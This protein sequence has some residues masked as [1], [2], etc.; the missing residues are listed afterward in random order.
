MAFPNITEFK[1]KLLDGGARP[2]LFQMELTFP[3]GV[4]LGP[5]LGSPNFPFACTISE[6]PGISFNPIT[7]KYAGR[8]VKYAGSRI[9]RNLT[10]TVLNDNGFRIRKA[11]EN[12]MDLIQSAESN[13]SALTS[14]L[15]HGATGYAGT[16]RV[17][18]YKTTGE[19]AR[20]YVFVD[21]FPMDLGA[22]QLNWQQEAI[23]EYTIEFAYQHWVPGE[24]F[25]G[26]VARNLV[27]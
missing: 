22:I 7:V 1:E 3:S 18:Q 16:G 27:G 14:P 21:L 23:E 13:V 8:E 19:V 10:V 15:S 9:Y 24:E 11:I 20:S 26:S 12:W 6:I 4:P 5:T 25:A 2:S 17:L